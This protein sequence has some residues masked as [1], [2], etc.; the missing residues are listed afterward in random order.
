MSSLAEPR[1]PRLLP[2]N[3]KLR[4]LKG[5][6]LRNLS[7]HPANLRTSEDTGLNKSPHKLH[8]L[9][10]SSQLHPS[11]SSGSLRNDGLP[12]PDHNLRPQKTRR[13]SLSLAHANPVARQKKL[14][15]LVDE[16]VGD[17]FYSLHVE[18]HVEPVYVSEMGEKSA[19]RRPLCAMLQ[20]PFAVYLTIAI[21]LQLPAFRP[22]RR[23][24]NRYKIMRHD[25]P[26]LGEAAEADSM[27]LPP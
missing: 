22:G 13:T 3:R 18:G 27:D 23:R 14:E 1:R 4:H 10:E 6:W 12:R 2:Q 8:V 20:S 24:S 9:K 16:T 21:E 5:I 7:F 25:R 11:R 15:S 26:R 17:V 19:V